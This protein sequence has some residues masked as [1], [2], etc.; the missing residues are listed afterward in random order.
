MNVL[1]YM[2]ALSDMAV[3]T[4]TIPVVDADDF[5][6]TAAH[7]PV[8]VV[9]PTIRDE[10][11]GVFE[12]QLETAGP[13]LHTTHRWNVT[14]TYIHAQALENGGGRF[15]TPTLAAYIEDY[16][17]ALLTL[18]SARTGDL[19]PLRLV[20]VE[21]SFGLLPINNSAMWVAELIHEVEEVTY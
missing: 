9:S 3:G 17:D 21:W 14:D 5:D 12:V 1:A 6:M 18:W 11:S 20:S 7:P 13:R 4:P 19:R 15:V 10:A 2:R 8:R 16:H